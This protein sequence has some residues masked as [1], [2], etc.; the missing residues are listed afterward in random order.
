VLA[1]SLTSFDPFNTP[2]HPSCFRCPADWSLDLRPPIPADSRFDTPRLR[3]ADSSFIIRLPPSRSG[4]QTP[5]WPPRPP[6]RSHALPHRV[7]LP[8]RASTGYRPLR[9]IE[10]R[11]PGRRIEVRSRCTRIA[12]V[13]GVSAEALR[14]HLGFGRQCATRFSQWSRKVMMRKCAN[15][16]DG[17]QESPANRLGRCSTCHPV[18][19]EC[20]A[21][22]L[23]HSELWGLEGPFYQL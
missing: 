19:Q 13:D 5:P 3:A 11:P 9:L 16:L 23:K 4:W 21:K 2:S 14:V 15:G 20:V 22:A 8:G 6:D 17:S 18:R 7:V 12:S 1:A 10:G